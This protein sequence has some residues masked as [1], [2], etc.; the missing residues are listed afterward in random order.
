MAEKVIKVKNIS[1]GDFWL[2]LN[3]VTKGRV[4]RMKPDT[5]LPLTMDEYLYLTSQC[6]NA[7]KK[8][9]LKSIEPNE[10]IAGDV[11]ETENEMS[12]QDIEDLM[13]L[14][15]AKLNNKLKTI[16]SEKL[17]KDIRSR[18]SELDK[19]D[20]FMNVID[21]RLEDVANGSILL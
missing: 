20:K 9:F 21:T 8:G 2:N 10:A 15:P 4:I 1:R 19:N 18:A 7:F 5:E 11:I 13:S 17:L 3:D 14:T 6:A 12:E 16:D